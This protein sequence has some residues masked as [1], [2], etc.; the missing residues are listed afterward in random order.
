MNLIMILSQKRSNLVRLHG[1]RNVR[2]CRQELIWDRTPFW[3]VQIFAAVIH[4]LFAG[5]VCAEE[6]KPDF[7]EVPGT[8]IYHSPAAS[9]VYVGSP[10]IVQLAKGDYLA[11]CD[12]FGPR[13]TEKT[14]GVTRVF[15]ST[16]R[17]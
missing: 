12:E 6:L 9:Q 2:P 8:V 5:I 13:S 4:F 10:G 17:G 1:Y 7:R 15:R 16:N 14:V 3:R 11:K